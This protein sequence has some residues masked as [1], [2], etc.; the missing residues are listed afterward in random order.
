MTPVRRALLGVIATHCGCASSFIAS[1]QSVDAQSA[2]SSDCR[3]SLPSTA[4]LFLDL[5]DP[6]T[7]DY[8]GV[9]CRDSWG[10]D[11]VALLTVTSGVGQKE[12]PNP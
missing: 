2:L 3:S 12:P 8:V 11:P 5:L 7:L 4:F 10:F 6:P 9:V 1:P